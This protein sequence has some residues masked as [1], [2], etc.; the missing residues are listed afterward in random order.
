MG[1][2]LIVDTHTTIVIDP[3]WQGQFSAA[4]GWTL[5]HT[6]K[7]NHHMPRLAATALEVFYQKVHAI[8][9]EMGFVLKIVRGIWSQRACTGNNEQC[10]CW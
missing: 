7:K 8:A 1:P 2:A 5:E 10:Q 6:Q 9:V 4:L 3:E